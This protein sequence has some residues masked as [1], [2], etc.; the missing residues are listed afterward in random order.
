MPAESPVRDRNAGFELIETLRWEPTG[1]SSALDR[2]L[3][4]LKASAGAL[5]FAFNLRGIEH[6]AATAC[7]VRRQAR[8]ASA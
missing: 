3:G 8:C 4:R 2:H 6:E 5:G 7:T 1:R